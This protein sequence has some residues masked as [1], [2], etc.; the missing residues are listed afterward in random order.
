MPEFSV[1][2]PVYNVEKYLKT[3]VDSILCQTYYDFEI[4]LVDD[5]SRDH[6]GDLCDE[7]GKANTC[8]KVVHKKNGG[9]SSA[10]NAG[11]EVATGKYVVFVDSDDYWDDRTALEHFHQNLAQTDADLLVFPAKRFY[12]EEK[13]FTYI[14]NLNVDRSKVIDTNVKQ[15]IRYLL[16]NNI[17]RAAAWNKVVKKA[18]IDAHR[19]RFKEGYLSED[20][21]WCGNLL[22]YCH[23]F[24]FYANPLYVY[25]QQRRGSITS[26]KTEKLVADKI[27]MC[28]KG[29]EQAM[30]LRDPAAKELLASYYAYEYAVMLGVSAGIRDKNILQQMKKLQVLL[31]YDISKKVK[32]V[33]RMKKIVGYPLTRLALCFFVKIKK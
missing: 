5:G 1:I 25:R 23:R 19:M 2:I 28:N 10:R 16:E 6:S 13:R 31:Q 18:V 15:A 26:G 24:D 3:C 11:L 20:M 27:Y 21:D 14:L 8:V 7:I 9:L 17:Y 29:Y 32:K 30:T 22:L 12:E 4:V 33:N